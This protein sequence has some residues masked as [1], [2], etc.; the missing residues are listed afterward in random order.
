MTTTSELRVALE[1]FLQGRIFEESGK[2]VNPTRAVG[3]GPGKVF[4]K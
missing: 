3:P 2:Y 1:N 4:N